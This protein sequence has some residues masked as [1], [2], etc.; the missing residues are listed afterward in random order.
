[1]SSVNFKMSKPVENSYGSVARKHDLK[2]SESVG[3]GV[4]GGAGERDDNTVLQFFYA[5][6]IKK[7]M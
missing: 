5:F 2:C 3:V 7:G 4:G 6:E 1:M